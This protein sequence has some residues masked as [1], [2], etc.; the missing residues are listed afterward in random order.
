MMLSFL[1]DKTKKMIKSIINIIINTSK[2]QN[3][4]KTNKITL[5]LQYQDKQNTSNMIKSLRLKKITSFKY[6]PSM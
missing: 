6:M 4:M 2:I 3:Y 5:K 1:F